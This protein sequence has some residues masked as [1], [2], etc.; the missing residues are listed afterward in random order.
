MTVISAVH[1]SHVTASEET[2]KFHDRTFVFD[3]LSIAYVLED[4]YAERTLA[5]G[6]NATN[7]TF[8]LEESW[9]VVM[10]NMEGN[11]SA[12]EKS[13]YL[14]LC[15]TADDMLKAKDEGKL[16]VVIGTQGA[17][18]LDDQLWRLE[19]LTRMGL[20][21]FGLAY[22]TANAFGD[23]CGEK[24]DAG[25]TYLGEELIALA[26]ALPLM[27]DLSHCGHRTRAEATALARAPVCT[28][29]NSD[30]LRS[31]GRNTEDATVRAMA[32]KGGMIGVCGLPQSLA[33]GTPTLDDFL[34]HVDHF[35]RLV[36][37]EHVGI[38]VDYVEKYQE[39]ASVVAP[40][41][42]VTWRTRRPDIFGPLSSFGR[43]S[44]PVGVETVAKLPNLTQGLL[45]RGYDRETTAAIMGGNWL[46][47][48]RRFCG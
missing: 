42:V 33:D 17:S 16:G 25:L 31:N 35:V 8:A 15:L 32:A 29:S 46:R 38:G 10:R 22:T 24:R 19:L 14:K 27:I 9:D 6:V 23:G 5:G 7:V 1:A 34:D 39:Q 11:L 48:F 4:K 18:M 20:R 45:D 28:H 30:G 26:D 2:R 47:T 12:I 36:G 13:P 40:P 43:Q 3:A 37:A 41:S 44:Y 21:I